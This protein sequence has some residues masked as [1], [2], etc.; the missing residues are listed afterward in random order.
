MA[1]PL[2]HLTSGEDWQAAL[3][4]GQ[5]VW[6]TRGRRLAEVGFVHCGYRHQVVG[7]ANELYGDT[8]EV[9][10]LVIESDRLRADVRVENLEGGEERYPHVYGPLDLDAVV[11]VLPMTRGLAGFRLP[12]G[13]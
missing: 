3:A 5:Y 1:E 9:V 8:S 2:F 10:L 13:V 4:S 7:V 11:E 12:P 6:S